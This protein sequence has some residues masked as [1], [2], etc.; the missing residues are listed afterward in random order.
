M[1][2]RLRLAGVHDLI[3]AE[4]NYHANCL[5]QFQRSTSKTEGETKD[6]EL[7]I[8]WLSN[9]LRYI[10]TKDLATED[11]QKSL[12]HA[13]NLGQ[14]VLDTF[15]EKRLIKLKG[16]QTGLKFHDPLPKVKPSTFSSLFSVLKQQRVKKSAI[17]AD[18]NILQRLNMDV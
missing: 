3:A 13:E 6:A 1:H 17:K 5:K 15:V 8:I 14:G 4:A 16:Q 9:E 10:A 12:L 11:I 2:L 18:R 7:P